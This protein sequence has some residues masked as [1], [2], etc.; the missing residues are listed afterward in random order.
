MVRVQ[1]WDLVGAEGMSQSQVSP[2]CCRET[3][4]HWSTEEALR[5]EKH[6]KYQINKFIYPSATFSTSKNI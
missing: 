2:A 1:K 3:H 5:M 6:F 4:L